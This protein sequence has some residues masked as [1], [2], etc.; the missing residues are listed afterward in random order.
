MRFRVRNTANR[1]GA[2]VAQLYVTF[3]CL[4]E[5]QEPPR[6]LKGFQGVVLAPGETKTV[7]LPLTSPQ[8]S[9]WSERHRAWQL[10]HG[11]FTVDV[12]IHLR[13]RRCR[14]H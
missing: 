2:D 6:Q 5:D 12:A 10:A 3:P 4:D 1:S 8:L 14:A 7:E 13:I 11:E 9:Y